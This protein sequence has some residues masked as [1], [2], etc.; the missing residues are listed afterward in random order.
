MDIMDPRTPTP[1]VRRRV[2]PKRE[3]AF[4]FLILEVQ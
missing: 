1:H 4:V 3:G 2:L